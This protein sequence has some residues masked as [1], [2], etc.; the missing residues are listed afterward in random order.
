[1][2]LN[3]D[4]T[5]VITSNRLSETGA[6]LLE[7]GMIV[8]QLALADALIIGNCNNQ[9]KEMLGTWVCIFGVPPWDPFWSYNTD[10]N[11][12][13]HWNSFIVMVAVVAGG[14]GFS[15]IR[16]K[17]EMSD[18]RPIVLTSYCLYST[19]QLSRYNWFSYTGLFITTFQH[20]THTSRKCLSQAFIWLT[21][22]CCIFSGNRKGFSKDILDP[23]FRW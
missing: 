2:V 19:C 22:A 12:G 7:Q 18:I 3:D 4:N 16:A 1:M 8:G 10:S 9:V 11:R 15:Q 14:R 23:V 13:E 6:P 17:N 20:G 5:I 21:P